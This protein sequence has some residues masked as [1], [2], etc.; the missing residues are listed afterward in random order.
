MKLIY[1]IKKD[2]NDQREHGGTSEGQVKFCFLYGSVSFV[3]LVSM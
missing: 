3:K 2:L 1:A